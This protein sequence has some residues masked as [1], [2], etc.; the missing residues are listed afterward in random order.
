[1]NLMVWPEPGRVP[2]LEPTTVALTPSGSTV[3]VGKVMLV[4]M[5]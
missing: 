5:K 3:D 1:M 2:A 4:P